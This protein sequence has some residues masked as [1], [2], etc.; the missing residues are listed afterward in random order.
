MMVFK[1]GDV[2]TFAR[3]AITLKNNAVPFRIVEGYE[4]GNELRVQMVLVSDDCK[5]Q[6]QLVLKRFASEVL[7]PTDPPT[8][9]WKTN[10]CIMI[11]QLAP[12]IILLL[13]IL[14]VW[15]CRR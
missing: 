1:S 9:D 15:L 14:I 8:P 3:A 7:L 2:D 4:G 6:A 12:L 11:A 5:E 13:F 10:R